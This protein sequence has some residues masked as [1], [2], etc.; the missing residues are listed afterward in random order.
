MSQTSLFYK[1]RK[2]LI[3]RRFLYD[4]L[5]T[6]RLYY[7][8]AVITSITVYTLD[9]PIGKSYRST[10]IIILSYS[11]SG[12]VQDAVN[13]GDSI[14]SGLLVYYHWQPLEMV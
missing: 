2:Q 3:P 12:G 10:C 14:S 6:W 9:P 5:L 4:M 1:R 7:G 13:S 8:G 11:E